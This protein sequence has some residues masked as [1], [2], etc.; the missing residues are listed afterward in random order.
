MDLI[1]N[2]K[3]IYFRQAQDGTKDEEHRE[4]KPYWDKRLE[5][6][7]YTGI[8]MRWGYPRS[9]DDSRIEKFAW[10]GF[11]KRKF[12]LMGQGVIWVYA[13]PLRA[14][15]ISGKLSGKQIKSLGSDDAHYPEKLK[16]IRG[17]VEVRREKMLKDRGFKR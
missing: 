2:V 8:Q 4:C 3:E 15:A 6:H 9:G 5:N 17:S 1:F 13:F 14:R 12:N 7:N 11:Y 10:C 16:K